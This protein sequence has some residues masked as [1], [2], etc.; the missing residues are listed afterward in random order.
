[1]DAS[2]AVA[3]WDRIDLHV[4][5]CALSAAVFLEWLFTEGPKA[6]ADLFNNT[7][8][9]SQQQ[10]K[11]CEGSKIPTD[12]GVCESFICVQYNTCTG[13][14][15]GVNCQIIEHIHFLQL[16][17]WRFIVIPHPLLIPQLLGVK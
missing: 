3:V 12:T 4:D 16:I 14:Q 7:Y 17:N 8:W 1:M 6:A 15:N 5:D 11:E 9:K 2:A 13:D 10:I